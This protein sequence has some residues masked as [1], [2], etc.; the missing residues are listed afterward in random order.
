MEP[1]LSPEA[2]QALATLTGLYKDL[3]ARRP[4]VARYQS[5][6]EGDQ[7]LVYASEAWRKEHADRY[8]NFS[9]NWCGVV[10]T[11]A[12]ERTEV[13]GIRLGDDVETIDDAE[14]ALWQD[15]LTNELPLQSSQGFLTSSIARRSYVQVW[16]DTDD[17]PVVE[18][19]SPS[20][21]IVA[22]T[23]GS[24]LRGRAALWSSVDG[25]FEY[26]TL[27]DGGKFLWKF[28]RPASSASVVTGATPSGIV[29]IGNTGKNEGW[30]PWQPAEDEV[31]PLPNP[32]GELTVREFPHKPMLARDPLSRIAGTMAMQD[33]INMLWAYLFVAADYA[34]MPARVVLGQEPPKL[35]ILDESGQKIGEKAVEIAE[36]ARGRMLWLTGQNSKIDSWEAAKLDVF[37]GVVNVAVKHIAAQTRTPIHYIVGELGNVNGETLKATET[38]LTAD[39]RDDHKSYGVGARGLFR[40]MALVRGN[41][42]VADACRTATIGWANPETRSDA[43]LADAALKDRQVGFPLEWIAQE[44][45]GYSQTDTARLMEMV[46][47]DPASA[48]LLGKVT[49]GLPG[50]SGAPDDNADS[51]S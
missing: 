15:W 11:A 47:N 33:A 43:Q 49:A 51:G 37:T 35:P 10:G 25:N 36:L 7:K 28:R 42:A 29:V 6:F 41:K 20:Q 34:S 50:M 16:G 27:D 48:G 26:A 12:A 8:K 32:L 39:V 1:T 19:M 44:R 5:Y 17:N 46:A 13:T 30:A 3:V 23:P 45:Y 24:Q 18:W 2:Q 38:P 22:Y 14:R 40:L 4:E 31:W 9:D 21:A